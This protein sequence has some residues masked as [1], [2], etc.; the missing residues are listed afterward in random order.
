MLTPTKLWIDQTHTYVAFSKFTSSV[1]PLKGKGSHVYVCAHT[2]FPKTTYASKLSEYVY[3]IIT[4][5]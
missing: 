5:P 4:E 1:Y 3:D 2:N